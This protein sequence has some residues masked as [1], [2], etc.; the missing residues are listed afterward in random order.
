MAGPI[1]LFRLSVTGSSHFL[2][3]GFMTS[4][5]VDLAIIL[6]C[7]RIFYTLEDD[8]VDTI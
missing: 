3:S 1:E 2:L 6:L 5:A 8:I 7:V 4:L